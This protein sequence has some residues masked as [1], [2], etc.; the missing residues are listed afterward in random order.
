MQNMPY[1]ICLLVANFLQALGTFMNVRWVAERDVEAGHYC[2]LQGGI[3]QAGNVGMALW[4]DNACW[5]C[6]Q[7]S[8]NRRQVLR[9]FCARI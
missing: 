2:S 9:T 3:K 1:F 5:A 7:N 8:L 6:A 4:L